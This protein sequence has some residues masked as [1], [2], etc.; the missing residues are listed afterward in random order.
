M[1]TINVTV[2]AEKPIS[3]NATLNAA[4]SLTLKTAKN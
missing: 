2:K 3:V 1:K 4:Q